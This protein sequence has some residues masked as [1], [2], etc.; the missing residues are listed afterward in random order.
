MEKPPIIDSFK[1]LAL[2]KSESASEEATEDHKDVLEFYRIQPTIAIPDSVLTPTQ[3]DN[4]RFRKSKPWGFHPDEVGAF[5]E[6]IGP[7]LKFYISAME[8]R[9]RDINRLATQLDKS[10]TDIQ[11]L[12]FQLEMFQGAGAQ[13]VVDKDGNFVSESDLSE[14]ELQL[15]KATAEVQELRNKLLLAQKDL[16]I[17][18]NSFPSNEAGLTDEERLELNS[19]REY[20]N[21]LEE[22][23]RSVTERYAEL[24]AVC[25]SLEAEVTQL[26]A[27][28]GNL[29]GESSVDNEALLSLQA[30]LEAVQN[31][32]VVLTDTI[33]SL[34]AEK[35]SLS[36]QVTEL[37]SAAQNT[38]NDTRLAEMDQYVTQME[39]HT[40]TLEKQLLTISDE[41]AQKDARIQQL[42]DALEERDQRISELESQSPD[43]SNSP[44][45][46]GYRDLP[47]GVRPEDLLGG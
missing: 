37:E 5:V 9:D 47:P 12:K 35:V 11:N 24:E 32:N 20:R 39:E 22:W 25:A 14:T 17:A 41:Q 1:K 10:S 3:V 26:R 2:G 28:H 45:L 4:V 31:E 30:D 8:T 40:D 7:T 42:M 46:S 44:I 15:E 18:Q 19:L 16:D 6:Q 27:H 21:Q 33:E 13:A 29:E 23:E 36:S 34:E 43:S 38:D